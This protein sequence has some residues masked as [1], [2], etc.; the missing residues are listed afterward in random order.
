M[1]RIEVTQARLM[2]EAFESGIEHYLPTLNGRDL[3]EEGGVTAVSTA[4]LNAVRDEFGDPFAVFYLNG[5]TLWLCSGAALLTTGFAVGY[6]GT[7]PIQLAEMVAACGLA[8]HETAKRNIIAMPQ[9]YSGLLFLRPAINE[10]WE[11]CKCQ[12]SGCDEMADY[13]GWHRSRDGFGVKTGMIRRL[14]VCLSHKS[15]LIGFEA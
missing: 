2:W 15:V 8:E 7:G 13:E 1:Q 11:A 4:N 12:V 10:T 5:T 3:S 9:N 6:S 14:C